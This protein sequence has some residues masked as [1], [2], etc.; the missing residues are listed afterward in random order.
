MDNEMNPIT[1][2]R[3]EYKRLHA[4]FHTMDPAFF[5]NFNRRS[6]PRTSP[7]CRFGES[8]FRPRFPC[9]MN[10]SFVASVSREHLRGC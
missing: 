8:Q 1:F 2:T 5:P 9:R 6:D 7:N 10:T 4:L 3:P